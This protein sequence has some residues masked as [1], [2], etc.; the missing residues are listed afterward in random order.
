V[1][2]FRRSFRHAKAEA[3]LDEEIRFDLEQETQLRVDRGESPEQ[4]RQ[5]ALRDFGNVALVKETTREMWGGRLTD[6]LARDVRHSMRLMARSP[7]FTAVAVL[8][9][10]LGIGANTAIFSL[11]NSL[12]LRPLP[13]ADP[14]R[15]VVVSGGGSPNQMWTYAIWDQI[16]RQSQSF[17]GA[18]AWG[19]PGPG[20]RFNLSAGG[21]MQ[22]IDG[23]F[24]SGGFFQTLGVTAV[25]G[26]TFSS[27]D[28]VRGGGPDGAVGVINYG[29]WQRQFAAAAS[30]VGTS[31]LVNQVPVTI[32]GVTP[33]DFFGVEVGHSFD[34]ALPIGSATLMRGGETFLDHRAAYWLNIVLRL[35]DGQA[36]EAGAAAL[37]AIQ[38]LIR[39][40]A[41]PPQGRAQFLRAPLTLTP[42]ASGRSELRPRYERPLLT[43]F[44]VVTLML[45]IACANIANLL[46]ARATARRHEFTVRLALGA[47][48][49][50]LARQMFV[51]HLVLS[52]VGA[53]VG[54]LFAMWGS[55]ALVAQLSSHSDRVFLDLTLDWRVLLFTTVVTL[56]T[57]LLF[58][59]APALR[60]TRAKPVHALMK[61]GGRGSAG[62]P[63]AGV[64]SAL[65]VTQVALSLVLVIG[66]GLFVRTFARL[67]NVSLGF[68]AE[69]VL[70]VTVN[71]SRSQTEPTRRP[72]LYQRL[73]DSV[74]VL[75]GVA[76]AAASATT[77][78]S[79]S[80]WGGN[81]IEVAGAPP[82]PGS[83]RRALVNFVTPHWFD[84]YGTSLV[85]GRDVDAQDTGHAPFVTLVNEAFVRQFLTDRAPLDTS[86][87]EF[88]SRTTRAIVGV[89]R[90]AVY[91]S[92]REASPPT[93]Y[94]PMLQFNWSDVPFSTVSISLRSTAGSP[95]LLAR[96]VAAALTE[97]DRDLAF[98]FRPLADQVSASILRER[99][100]AMLS[101]LFGVLALL[102]AGLG[103]YGVTSYTVNR[104][105][106]ELGIRMALGAAPGGV[107]RLVMSRAILLVTLGV[108]IGGAVSLW[109]SRFVAT[110]LYGIEPRDPATVLAAALALTTIGVL[111]AWLPAWRAS[112]IDPARA[113]RES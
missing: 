8:S 85:A 23:I 100:M 75:P 9:L 36:S 16:Q 86:I 12:L 109:A 61:D 39:D 68:D 59:T 71:A 3:E 46:L 80:V 113:L 74:A 49:W 53:A 56:G 102:L 103:L 43:I 33:P 67:A 77:P 29:F 38:P 90:D 13:V 52:T 22:P 105:R 55:R 27:T 84:T 31:L 50:R 60:G 11:V 1:F 34:M 47:G 37:R 110:L 112:R 15:L 108:L 82:I 48:R 26:R 83:E 62:N 24:A 44:G 69:R 19:T 32:I 64:S 42:A 41:M 63:R 35:K 30:V 45:L 57:T 17:D 99:L 87:V 25:L 97:A 89:V 21:E 7:M 88:P 73:A 72:E 76:R 58:G 4:A 93:M 54:V 18:C 79:Q 78:L 5:A 65:V 51:E 10:A 14:Q 91:P 95:A 2:R 20:L 92:V 96:A 6:D 94:V 66:A 101:G 81:R 98:T 107:V 111:S 40:G 70:V 28:D 104:R 106:T